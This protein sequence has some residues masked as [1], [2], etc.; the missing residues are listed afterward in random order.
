MRSIFFVAAAF[1][2]VL[3]LSGQTL[4][5]IS[6]RVSDSSGSGVPG[7]AL[8]LTNT[9]TNAT[10]QAVTGD[11]GFYDFPDVPPGVY[12][13]KTEHTGFKTASS[14]NVEVQVQQSVRL[15]LTLEV[16]QVTETVQ[17]E[18]AAE[19]LQSSDATI[20]TVIQQDAVT[21]LP[22]NGRGYLN[23]VALSSNANTLSPA[24]GQ[25]QSR[26]GG[27]RSNQAISTGGNRIFFDYYTLD[28]VIN[29]DVDFN[30]YIALPSIDAIQEFKVQ[31]GVYPAEFGHGATQ[32]NVVTKSGGNS[33]HGSLF[34]FVRNDD[35]DAN[36]A[37]AFTANR[38]LKSPFK[39]N[40]FG[41]VLSGPIY[42]PKLYN[43]R[44]RF[45]FMT[46]YEALIQRQSAQTVAS[47]PTAAMQ[48]GNF[49]GYSSTIYEPGSGGVPFPNNIIPASQ[50]NPISQELLKYYAVPTLPGLVN[51]YTYY[52]NT[53]FNRY[54]YVL[55]FDFIESAKSQWTGRYNWGSELQETTGLSITGFKVTTGYE[56][57]LGTNTRTLTPNL[58][59]EVRF[60]YAR[61]FNAIS[62]LSAFVT[63]VVANMN[64]AIPNLAPGQPVQ[65]GVP[66]ESFS[67]DGFTAIGDNSD[68][69]YQNQN[70]YAQFVDNLSWVKG[71]HTFKFGFE[72]NRQ[73]F[74]QEGNQYLRGGF[75]FSP[76][77]TQ[78]PLTKAGGD[79]FAEYL[80]GYIFQ[81][82]TALQI[83]K[84]A[85][86]RNVE[87][88]FVDDTW[89]ITPKLTLSLGLRYELTPP[90]T[91]TLGNLF[92]IVQ[93][94]ISAFSN[95]PVSTEPYFIR[96]GNC[97][98][99]YTATPS[100]PF[101]WLDTPA[102]CSNGLE[103]YNL[104]KTRH[105]DF[106]PRVSLVYSPDSKTVFRTGFGE[107][108][109]Q[110]NGN[111]MY[112]D[113]S[114]NIGVRFTASA[115][116][117]GTVWSAG[118]GALA[119]LPATWA[120]AVT[121]AGAGF[122]APYGYT[123]D[124]NHLTSY[125]LQY[126]FNVQRQVGANWAFEAGYLGSES[127][128]LYGFQNTNDG[129]PGTVGTAQSR[130]PY[131]DYG[132]IQTVADGINAIYNSLSFKVTKRLSNGLDIISSYTFSKSID[133]SSGIRVQGY[134][135]LFPQNSY[136]IECER[137]LSAFDVRNRFVTSV[138]YDLP[139]G[140][141]K[142]L[143]ITNS[144]ANAIIGG[145]ETG[146]IVTIQ[147]GLPES[148][149][150]GGVD[151]SET[152]AGYDRPSGTGA[153]AYPSNQTTGGWF[154][155]AA[156]VEAAPGTYGN[157]GRNTL[158]TPGTFAINAEVHKNFHIPKLENHQLQFRA[159]AFNVLN[160]PNFGEPNPDILAGAAFPGQ[161]SRDAHQGFGVISSLA[162]LGPGATGNP[163]VPMRQ[164]QLALKYTF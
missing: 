60:G 92:E 44:N 110:D 13:L 156:F 132:F 138:L 27:D 125:T 94:Q 115:V 73:N 147:S 131:Q 108:F 8:T 107:F 65:W 37:F 88:A 99:P 3:P 139:V 152:T 30:T 148:L 112:F 119:G 66:P 93:P 45:F 164:L 104:D 72:Y 19:L 36:N 87:A 122:G 46:N 150:I 10:R 69:P 118:S 39:W 158:I 145:W 151:N 98:N 140:K 29:T 137:G 130:L 90:F 20:G 38:P 2:F 109:V 126:M 121:P 21:Q 155:P 80:L 101:T 142:Q 146:G 14:T 79:A 160:H 47:L 41:F 55:R 35:F 136:C 120:N 18:G 124:Y 24:A 9:S 96:Q 74:D 63:N 143:N 1:A 25:A 83:A 82:T 31:T 71:K 7:A 114:R 17:V 103:N 105:D 135:T 91:D 22:L 97:T 86:V 77:A 84:M 70:N 28:G 12:S 51:N 11:D 61:F 16:G 149:N 42:I 59:N 33:F 89:K 113:M 23:L 117:D 53:P 67:G 102:V 34:E 106:A 52:S 123:N 40:D 26:Q 141:G 48:G 57:Y 100:I 58:V 85:D 157:V 95:A 144:F 50:I 15:D 133:D 128:H 68:Y 32:V 127:H 129:I 54:G 162:G 43:G 111:S 154:N 49:S 81:S 4:G 163:A 78:D 56:Q 5:E 161:S 159:E 76:N 6:G 134:D 116:T 62:P 64:P 75:T 153:P